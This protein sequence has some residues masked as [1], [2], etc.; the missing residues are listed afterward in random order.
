MSGIQDLRFLLTARFPF[1]AV[2]T[3]EE[4]RAL[5]LLK[6]ESIRRNTPVYSWS[7]TEGLQV[8]DE[9]E[10]QIQSDTNEPVNLL[11]EIKYTLQPSLFI[12][13]DFHEYLTDAPVNI[14]LMRE[15]ALRQDICP[16]Q[17]ILLSPKVQ[18]PEVLHEYA[19]HIT[20]A[21]PNDHQLR[22]IILDESQEWARKT[23]GKSIKFKEKT[24]QDLIKSF[25]GLALDD[26][27]KLIR[28]AIWQDKVFLQDT[29]PHVNKARESLMN[30]ADVISFEYD[31]TSFSAVAGLSQLKACLEKLNP[32]KAPSSDA[33]GVFIFG[34][35]GAGKSLAARAAAG[36]WEV[37]LLRVNMSAFQAEN[38][39]KTTQHLKEVIEFAERLSPCIL[40]LDEIEKALLPAETEP[41]NSTQ[42][43]V[44][45][46]GTGMSSDPMMGSPHLEAFRHWIKEKTSN[47]FVIATSNDVKSLPDVWLEPGLFNEHFFIDLPK[48]PNRENLLWMHLEKRGFK[49]KEFDIPKLAQACDEFSG[50]E[51]EQA[52]ISAA[53]SYKCLNETLDSHALLEQIYKITP[54]SVLYDQEMTELREWAKGRSREAN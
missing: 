49:A 16:H 47:V 32:K 52:V 21:W 23:L 1:I 48:I 39:D 33:R 3:Y 31:T 22:H 44:Y 5:E 54:L 36:L 40:W 15:I 45:T 13:C 9:R 43:G 38:C 4:T 19:A 34:V 27:K 8:L 41:Q 53:Y 46:I 24:L 37:P 51:I 18:L 10:N 6:A 11:Q 28:G 26:A 50:S 2:E 25:H 12:L 17:I 30:Q 35:K 29:N 14:R 7:I 20:M 42:G